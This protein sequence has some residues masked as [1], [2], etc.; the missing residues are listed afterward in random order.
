M[1]VAT[2][3]GLDG[4][5]FYENG[6]VSLNLPVCAQVLGGRASR[7]THPQ[8]L[9]RMQS[10]FS[11]ILGRPFRVENPFLWRTKTE[12]TA[13]VRA[14]ALG[15]LIAETVSCAHTWEVTAEQPHCGKCSQCIDRRLAAVAAGLT[16]LEDPAGR[17]RTAVLT[18]AF[19]GV[20]HQT[21]VERVVGMAHHVGGMTDPVR[22]FASF[23]EASRALGYVPGESA[24][25][26]AAHMLDLFR[27]H[28]GQVRGA[29]E[30]AGTLATGSTRVAGDSL[31]GISGVQPG[32]SPQS[33][34]SDPQVDFTPNTHHLKILTVL[35]ATAT[36]CSI[37]QLSGRAV[38]SRKTVG[39]RVQDLLRYRCVKPLGGSRSGYAITPHGR[40]L[41]S[42]VNATRPAA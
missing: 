40:A 15:E 25:E 41:L 5:R 42:R 9:A 38:I 2:S 26:V 36:A 14:A 34:A 18:G 24:D 33:A 19:E 17:Y 35:A 13:G 30:A 10:L 31:L 3:F 32:V 12:V 28:S 29:I 23:G 27:R 21:M 39:R 11:L 8:T 6:V 7:T 20:E 37:K 22:L 16:D 1:A 4:V